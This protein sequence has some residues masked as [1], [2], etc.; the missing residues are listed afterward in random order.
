MKK[1]FLFLFTTVISFSLFAQSD[2]EKYSGHEIGINATA[3]VKEFL[4]LNASDVDEGPYMITYKKFKNGRALRL[5]LGGQ[6][7]QINEDI[8]GGG[9]L[10]TKDNRA[11]LR[12]GYEWNQAIS[13]RWSFYYGAD[14]ITDFT[15][16]TS[17]TTSFLPTGQIES[18][19]LEKQSLTTGGGPIL[20]IQFF[21]TDKISLMTE[22]SL[23]YNYTYN[24]DKQTFDVETQFNKSEDSSSSLFEFGLPTA[25]FFVIR[26]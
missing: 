1:S 25:L 5:G 7:S 11:S 8:D 16:S 6:F 15:Q 14:V 23:Y 24:T 26:F 21:I 9:N 18:V 4:S 22:G 20:G 19:I 12:I 17:Q 10:T 3:F 2:K 13:K